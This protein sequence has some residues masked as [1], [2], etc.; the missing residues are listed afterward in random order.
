MMTTG[1]HSRNSFCDYDVD[2]EITAAVNQAKDLIE[3]IK[4]VAEN[5]E[6]EKAI[7]KAVI[8]ELIENL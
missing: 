2:H 6:D 4:N 3:E 1:K 8:S 7:L 5:N